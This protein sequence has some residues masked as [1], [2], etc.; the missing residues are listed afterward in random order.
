MLTSTPEFDYLHLSSE[1]KRLVDNPDLPELRV[2]I[3]ADF[4]TQQLVDI[5][6]VLANRSGFRLAVYEA[7]YDTIDLEIFNPESGLYQFKPS[8]VFLLAATEK[9]KARYY[10][11]ADIDQFVPVT[12]ERFVSLWRALRTRSNATLIQSTYVRPSERAFG[13]FDLLASGSL[14]SAVL[15]INRGLVEAARGEK[16]VLLCDFDHLAGEIGRR[17]WFDERLWV[18]AKSPCRL[19]HLPAMASQLLDVAMAAAGRFVKCVI[20]DLD[21][22]LWGGVIGDDGLEG[23]DLG[24]FDEG[25]AFVAFQ[26]FLLSLR[27]RGIILAVV[28]KNEESNARL[29]FREH[30]DMVLREEDISVFVANWETKADNIRLV[31]KVLN[32]GFDSMVFLDD[33]PFERNLVRQFTPGVIVPELPEDPSLYMKAVAALNLFETASFSEADRQR[34]GQ[35]R[36]EASRALARE[37]YTNVDDYLR[38]LGMVARLERF[39]DRNI[40]RIAQLMQRSN[41]FNLMTRRHSE[42]A[43]A[44]FMKA[45]EAYT[46]I[47]ISLA[48]KF[49]DYGLISVIVLV[50]RDKEIEIDDYLMSCRVLKR[51]VEQYAMNQI[52]ALAARRNAERVI[53]RWRP[54]GK[55]DMVRGFYASFGFEQESEIDGVVTWVKKVADWTPITTFIDAAVNEI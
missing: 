19:D 49:G 18:L 40:A 53:G 8:C 32:I 9:L 26:R 47:T 46:P 6:R 5:L 20:L 44:E 24:G 55:N 39:C 30:P 52:F 50:L 41:Q 37:T 10:A 38:S 11:S 43:C 3:L 48:D 16:G 29:P 27:K 35:Y 22:T 54:T 7:G 4:A 21:N 31:Q 34:P 1:A 45:P 2:A 42:A 33:N 14:G 13:N 36:E 51:G 23:I 25:E 17:Q 15:E 12:V 28:S